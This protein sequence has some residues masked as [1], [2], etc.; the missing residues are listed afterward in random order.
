MLAIA[1][2]DP[3]GVVDGRNRDS[4]PITIETLIEPLIGAYW[5]ESSEVLA[6]IAELTRD[7]AVRSRI[8]RELLARPEHLPSCTT[9]LHKTAN[10]HVWTELRPPRRM[11]RPVPALQQQRVPAP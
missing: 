8:R 10:G 1:A 3:S 4:G 7:E 11:G 9:A 5:I 2:P 6:V